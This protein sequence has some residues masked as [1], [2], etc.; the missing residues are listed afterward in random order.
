MKAEIRVMS[1]QSK[2]QPRLLAKQQKLG[3][4]AGRCPE[5]EPIPCTLI[6]DF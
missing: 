4:R 6:S 3:E 2:E 5:K 1:L